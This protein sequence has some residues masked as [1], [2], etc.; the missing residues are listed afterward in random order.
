MSSALKMPMKAALVVSRSSDRGKT[1]LQADNWPAPLMM[2]AKW[3][4]IV[5]IH[6][7]TQ[8]LLKRSAS[9]R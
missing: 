2:G 1:W 4:A 9:A 8:S 3:G 6:E 5:G 7:A